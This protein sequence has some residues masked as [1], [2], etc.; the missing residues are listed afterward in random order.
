R[1]GKPRHVMTRAARMH[2]EN[3]DSNRPDGVRTVYGKDRA[4][5]K[6]EAA[7]AARPTF[8]AP[9][10]GQRPGLGPEERPAVSE[11]KPARPK[12]E[13]ATAVRP[14]FSGAPAEASDPDLIRG[15]RPAVSEGKPARPK[16]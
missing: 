5:P 13:V 8:R 11:G 3:R 7:T 6:V 10:G 15:K 1:A 16:A 14:T 12:A 4:R 9:R 2:S